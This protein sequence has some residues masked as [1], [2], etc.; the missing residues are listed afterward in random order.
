M[1]P[2]M[3]TSAHC[4]IT[5]VLKMRAPA[6]VVSLNCGMHRIPRKRI[7]FQIYT[8]AGLAAAQRR[9]LQ[10][11]GNERDLEPPRTNTGNRYADAVNADERFIADVTRE[12]RRERNAHAFALSFRR[13]RDHFAGRIDVAV[14]EVAADSIAQTQRIFDVDYIA[15]VQGTQIRTIERFGN[16][17]EI[18]D[19]VIDIGRRQT[20]AVD[21]D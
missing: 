11:F 4:T 21:R 8:V 18:D 19:V 14:H 2:A 13:T 15:L 7:D 3:S 16:D 12:L 1:M 10:R 5:C 6:G 20:H 9:S 17:V